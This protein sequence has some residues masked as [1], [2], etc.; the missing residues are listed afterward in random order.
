MTVHH[1]P[2]DENSSMQNMMKQLD[3]MQKQSD[4]LAHNERFAN[5]DRG[6]VGLLLD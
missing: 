1:R 4:A 3:I 2:F 5:R 6:N